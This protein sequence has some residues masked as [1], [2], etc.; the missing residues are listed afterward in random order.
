MESRIESTPSDLRGPAAEKLVDD[1]KAM[2]ERAEQKAI[3]RAKAADRVIREHPYQTIGLAFGVGLL[4][5][6]LARRK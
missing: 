2:L 4:I 1:L 5:G 3:E 6:F